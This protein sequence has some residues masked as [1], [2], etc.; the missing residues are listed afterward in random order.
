MIL[1]AKMQVQ[2]VMTEEE[3]SLCKTAFYE[4]TITRIPYLS[5]QWVIS[6]ISQTFSGDKARPWLVDLD[7][8]ARSLD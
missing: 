1:S 8:F 4:E 6:S 5:G 3:C 2:I 7:L